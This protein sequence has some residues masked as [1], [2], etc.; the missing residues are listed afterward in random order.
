MELFDFIDKNQKATGSISER[1]SRED[2]I[3]KAEESY[4][5]FP[6]KF[7]TITREEYL[8]TILEEYD[9]IINL[10]NDEYEAQMF[11]KNLRAKSLLKDLDNALLK[12]IEEVKRA[13][14]EREKRKLKNR[15]KTWFKRTLNL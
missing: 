6:K 11:Q 13:E 15:L 2:I 14:Q 1:P 4:D 12:K 8:T 3:K 10:P 5:R 7:A 9:N